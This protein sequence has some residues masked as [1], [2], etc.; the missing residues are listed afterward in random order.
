MV[1]SKTATRQNGDMHRFG[2]RPSKV[3]RF[4]RLCYALPLL[5]VYGTI[6]VTVSKECRTVYVCGG[7]RGVY[8]L[9]EMPE[10]HVELDLSPFWKC[11][12]FGCRRFGCVA[13]LAVAVL[14]CRRFDRYPYGRTVGLAKPY[15]RRH[16]SYKTFDVF[17]LL[18][19]VSIFFLRQF[20]CVVFCVIPSLTRMQYLRFLVNIRRKLRLSSHLYNAAI[21]VIICSHDQWQ[22][23]I[24]HWLRF[25]YPY[26][27]LFKTPYKLQYQ[28]LYA[29]Q[30]D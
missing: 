14:V 5:G 3:P 11:R 17:L 23:K 27:T 30:W 10:V 8:C 21:F 25:S 1:V 29:E 22:P 9:L 26:S 12:R 7:G 28:I 19:R 15:Y 2:C 24:K 20:N 4:L 18:R 16:N 13:V 6:H